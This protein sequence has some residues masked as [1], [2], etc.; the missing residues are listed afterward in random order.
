M[1]PKL[2]MEDGGRNDFVLGLL[3]VR[4]HNKLIKKT[5]ATPHI[6]RLST[7]NVCCSSELVLQCARQQRHEA[8]TR[9]AL[10]T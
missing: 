10:K 4:F 1:N 7:V 2:G 9:P 6:Q 8:K 5:N 3:S